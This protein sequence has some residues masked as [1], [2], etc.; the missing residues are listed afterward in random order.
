MRGF[1]TPPHKILTL[2]NAGGGET[3]TLTVHALPIFFNQHVNTYWPPPADDASDAATGNY[4]H[5]RGMLSA[6]EGLRR[7]EDLPPAPA[8]GAAPSDWQAH[9]EALLEV[10]NAA[11]FN[12]AQVLLIGETARELSEE[13]YVIEEI[14]AAGND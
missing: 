7:S 2:S 1:S 5:L 3:V 9:A 10:F 12:T 11:G 14:T 13:S 6:A 4:Y 8:P